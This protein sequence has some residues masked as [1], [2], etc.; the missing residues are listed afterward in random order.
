MGLPV[1]DPEPSL[2]EPLPVYSVTAEP[3]GESEPLP[4]GPTDETAP[5]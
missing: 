5:K 4:A 2:S 1:T 3:A